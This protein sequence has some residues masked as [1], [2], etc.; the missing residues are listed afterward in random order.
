[1]NKVA[2]IIWFFSPLR[3]IPGFRSWIK[4][5][6]IK[7]TLLWLLLVGV[8]TTLKELRAEKDQP[9]PKPTIHRPWKIEGDKL[10]W[11]GPED[12]STL[13]WTPTFKKGNAT[14][15]EPMPDQVDIIVSESVLKAELNPDPLHWTASQHQVHGG[16]D[17]DDDPHDIIRRINR[18]EK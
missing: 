6:P 7:A 17:M 14:V 9:K 5:H 4:D 10:T 11:A 1:M 2:A 12:Q 16:I 8:Q 3:L 15:G 18:E 13:P